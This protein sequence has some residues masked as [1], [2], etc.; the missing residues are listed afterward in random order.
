MNITDNA[1]NGEFV[2]LESGISQDKISAC[3]CLG[4]FILMKKVRGVGT[5]NVVGHVK[6]P[7]PTPRSIS[8]KLPPLCEASLG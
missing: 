8:L 5:S 4:I 3:E 7:T 6:N 2:Q 1:R